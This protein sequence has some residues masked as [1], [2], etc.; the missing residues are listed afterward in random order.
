MRRLTVELPFAP[1]DYVTITV[2]GVNYRGRIFDVTIKHHGE[3]SYNVNFVD[4]AA[5]LQNQSFWA[6]E[7]ALTADMP[8]TVIGF[9]PG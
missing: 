9:V 6:D 1:G 7:L 8:T 2:L 3:V 4:D 5:K